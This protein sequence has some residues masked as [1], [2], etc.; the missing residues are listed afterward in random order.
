MVLELTGGYVFLGIYSGPLTPKGRHGWW[1]RI[2][3]HPNGPEKDSAT[4]LTRREPAT[5]RMLTYAQVT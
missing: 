2:E 3:Y 1:L 4:W 5:L